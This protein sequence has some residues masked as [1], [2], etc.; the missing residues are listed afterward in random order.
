[1]QCINKSCHIEIPEG[2]AFC[3]SCGRKQV[4]EKRKRVRANGEGCV[5]QLPNMKYRAVRELGTYLDDK[6]KKHRVTKSKSFDKKADALAHLPK[7]TDKKGKDITLKQLY[8]LWL[9]THTA[10]KSTMN[11]YAAG[12]NHLKT[13][14]FTKVNDIDID[15]FQECVSECIRGKRTRQNMRT[16]IGLLYKYGIPR[17]FVE[18]KLNLA[19][20]I[21]VTGDDAE[22][23]EGFN[24]EQVGIIKNGVGVVKYANYIYAFIYLGFRPSEFL[25]L[26]VRDYNRQERAFVGGAKTD[27]GFDRTVTVSPKIQ[28]IIDELTADKI[29][30]A[31][32]CAP[33]GTAISLSTFRERYFY[34]TM[35]N[36][37]IENPITETP[38]GNRHKY[39]PHS[40]RHTFATLMKRVEA[41]DADKLA[42][43]GHS[44][45][46]MLRYYQDVSFADLRKITDNL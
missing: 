13:L 37:G 5:Y 12:M 28:S 14:W 22:H 33:D 15:D 21:K 27:A 6:G 7:L 40:C 34:P 43:I 41:P 17:G 46:E 20:Y 42:I 1:L 18:S 8:D 44:S 16:I 35:D 36:L 30:G 32:F 23:K 39:T 45:D 19:E 24:V 25:A 2:A 31:V 4:R 26:D 29:S 10:V 38:Q 3:F 9:P 11:C